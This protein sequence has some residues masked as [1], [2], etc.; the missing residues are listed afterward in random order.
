MLKR[1]I[2]FEDFDGNVQ[3]EVFYFNMSKAELIEMEV[4]K[5]E[6]FV[7]WIK[8][9]VETEDR[10]AMI[11]AFKDIVL[12]AYGVKSDDGKRF[13]KTPEV[14]LEFSQ[15]NAYSALF[16]ELATDDGAAATFING[17]MPKDLAAQVNAA[18][19]VVSTPS[20]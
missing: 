1:E 8:Q 9:I 18:P 6:G 19:A 7:D 10:K 15:T 16:M 12:R 11:G 20:V 17:I 14:A 13:I 2:T 5:K 3:T 4:E